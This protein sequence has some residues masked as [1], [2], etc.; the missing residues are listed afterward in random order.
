[1]TRFWI[2]AGLAAAVLLVL[3]TFHV[4]VMIAGGKAIVALAVI[5]GVVLLLARSGGQRRG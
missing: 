3:L 2:L 1:M 4:R 5:A